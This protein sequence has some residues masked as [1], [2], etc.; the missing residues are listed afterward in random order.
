M[1]MYNVPQH[2]NVEN[3]RETIMTQNPEVSLK[4]VDIAARFTFRIKRERINVVKAVCSGT[5]KK[6]LHTQLKLGWLVCNT[7]DYL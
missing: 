4:Q 2:M 5:R 7:D 3:L 6:R 1:V